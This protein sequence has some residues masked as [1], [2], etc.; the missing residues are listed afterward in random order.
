MSLYNKKHTFFKN[1]GLHKL[2]LCQKAFL[3]WFEKKI[4]LDKPYINDE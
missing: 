4:A 3:S 1:V 2:I